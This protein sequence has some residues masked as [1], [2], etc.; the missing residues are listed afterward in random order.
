MTPTP[1]K[2]E[3]TVTS[4]KLLFEEAAEIVREEYAS[5]LVLEEIA[6]R[7]ASSRR[8]VQRAFSEAGGTTFRAYLL[9]V[10]MRRA[11]ELLRNG[12]VPIKRIAAAVG[13]RQPAQFAK[14]FRRH[15]G[16]TPAAFRR[17]GDPSAP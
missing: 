2:R 16:I 7:A 9:Q 1:A 15:N 14:A 17:D 8:Q 4:R 6:R 10:R 5:E 11:A 13:Y 12:D 3:S